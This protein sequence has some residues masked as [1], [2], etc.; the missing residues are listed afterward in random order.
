VTSTKI[1]ERV[2]LKGG[3]VAEDPR[4]G[5]V[6]EYDPANRQYNIRGLLTPLQLQQ[7]QSKTWWMPSH[8]VQNKLNQ[9]GSQ[10]TGESAL[11]DL[12]MSP[13]PIKRQDGTHFTDSDGYQIYFEARKWDQ[14]AGEDYEGSSVLGA[15]KALMALG[16]I[17]EYR[18]AF[19]ID[20]LIIALGHLGGVVLGTDWTNTMFEPHDNGLIVP[21]DA[22]DIA[23]GHAYYAR[24]VYLSPDYQRRLLGRGEPIRK[25]TPLLRGPNS[26]GNDWSRDGDWLMW[27]DDVERLLKGLDRWAGEARITTTAFR[28]PKI[29]A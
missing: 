23:G 27:A 9:N 12:I 8:F 25:N 19:D 24:S 7:P 20:D 18:W 29:T 11:Y 5:R 13:I 17:G 6:P 15:A 26:W 21:S 10:C 2:Q 1:E 16:Y 28:R 22:N 14:W 4:L 3:F